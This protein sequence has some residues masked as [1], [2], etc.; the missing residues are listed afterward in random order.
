MF[1]KSNSSNVQ[2]AVQ[3]IAGAYTSENLI[4][5]LKLYFQLTKP[6][7]M[8]LVLLTGGTAL[9]LQGSLISRSLDFILIM[10]GLFLTGGGANALNQCFERDIDSRMKRTS[11]RRPLPQGNLETFEAFAF[12][13]IISITGVLLFWY[14]FNLISAAAAL[15]TILFYSIFYT[16]WLKPNT[17]Q[18][19]VIG[20]A[21]GAA[22]PIIAWLAVEGALSLEPI[23]LFLIVFLW[24]PPHFWSLA[25]YYKDDYEKVNL[26]MMPVIAGDNSTL[27]QIIIYN[28]LMQFSVL[29]LLLTGSGFIYG[30]TALYF[31]YKFLRKS[32]EAKKEQTRQSYIG[33]F[34]YSII[35]LFAVLISIIADGMINGMIF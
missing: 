35:Y 17:P 22:A 10:T 9:Y 19:I 21:A 25:L 29:S 18:N 14:F 20:G 3:G 1:Y 27:K 11:S 24:T 2:S 32:V 13:I 6:S 34:K 33:L 26:P 4:T 5:K 12:A 30:I 15:F 16:L 23:I 28:I 31:G 7:I 8:L